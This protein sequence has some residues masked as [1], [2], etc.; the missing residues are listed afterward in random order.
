MGQIPHVVGGDG[1]G[2]EVATGLHVMVLLLLLT[3]CDRGFVDSARKSGAPVAEAQAHPTTVHQPLTLGV[4]DTPVQDANGT[5]IGVACVTCH[6]PDATTAWASGEGEPFHTGVKL[7]H[8]SLACNSCHDT[9][10]TRLHLADGAPVAFADTIQLCAQCH[11]AKY[12]SYTHGA[13]G[14]MNGYW[15][16][17]RGPRLKNHCVDC[18]APHAPAYGQVTPVFPPADRNPLEEH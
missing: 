4:V 12:D 7:E 9:D 16:T 17:R 2:P 1:A 14:G 13:H 3:A 11:G 8:G 5:P 18:H 6:G 15:D 10:R